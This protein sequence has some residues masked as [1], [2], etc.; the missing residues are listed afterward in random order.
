MTPTAWGSA[1]TLRLTGVGGPRSCDLV[2]VSAQGASQTVTS[3][4]VPP[5]DYGPDSPAQDQAQDRAQ[6]QSQS[7]PQLQTS[8]G[9]GFQPGQISHFEVRDLASGQLL[10]SVPAD[11]S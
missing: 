2:A 3:W 8:G 10:I 6:G 9:T 11:G 1:I 4:T 7:G 5:A